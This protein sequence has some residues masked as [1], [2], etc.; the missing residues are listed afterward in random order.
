MFCFFAASYYR[1][2]VGVLVLHDFSDILFEVAKIFVYR[3]QETLGRKS[4]CSGWSLTR[5]T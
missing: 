1:F 2:G 5:D 3:E 4:R